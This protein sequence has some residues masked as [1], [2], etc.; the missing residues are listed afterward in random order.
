MVDSMLEPLSMSPFRDAGPDSALGVETPYELCCRELV[1]LLQARYPL[2]FLR[3]SDEARALRCAVEAHERLL[4]QSHLDRGSL[5]RWSSSGGFLTWEAHQA[6]PDLQWKKPSTAPPG[7]V[8]LHASL[9]SLRDKLKLAIHHCD[10]P[11]IYL[12]PDWA[13]LMEGTER[14]ILAR[15]LKELSL[16]IEQAFGQPRMTLIIL[17]SDWQIPPLLRN[18][19]HLLDLPLPNGEELFQ[20]V[21]QPQATPAVPQAVAHHLAEQAQGI[22]LQAAHQSARLIT[23][24]HLWQEPRQAANLLLE[25]KKQEIRKTGILEYYVPQGDSL[26]AVGGLGNIKRWIASREAWF[27]QDQS[28]A[29]RPR[30]IL[31]EGF[32]GC[33]KTL[34]ARAIAQEWGVPQ[35]NFEISRLQSKWAGESESQTVAALAAIEASAPNV[36]FVDEIEKAF[37]GVGGDSSGIMTRQLGM[38]LTWLNDHRRPIFLIA[39]SN[40]RRQ[41][42]PELFRAGRFDEIFIVMPPDA[43]ERQEILGQR[44]R[45]YGVDPIPPAVLPQL[46]NQTEGFSGAELDRLVR[47][48]RYLAGQSAVPTLEQ[49]QRSLTLITPQIRS[50]EMQA[51]LLRYL[52]LL[53]QGCGRSASDHPDHLEFLQQLLLKG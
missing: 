15:Q 51:L 25:V 19:V 53:E 34:I 3:S 13:D 16:A 2:V 23:T 35:I 22:S 38:F 36:L 10:R 28:P 27:E 37:A 8:S 49:W 46:L 11:Y 26:G 14:S 42:P 50:A 4:V 47:E 52:R 6:N 24:H 41:L 44:A 30:A 33:G 20:Q 18:S 40:D 43:Q 39:T 31:L 5:E 21:F 48:A 29:L 32:P 17:G 7:I 45:V 12:L 9:E 1:G